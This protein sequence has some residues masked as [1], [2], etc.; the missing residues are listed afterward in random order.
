MTEEDFEMREGGAVYL[1]DKGRKKVVT[2]YQNRKK[3]EVYHPLLGRKIPLGL[4]AHIQARLLARHL[5]G[6]TEIYMPLLLK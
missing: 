4:A 2:G 5:R 1:N 3:D 6:D